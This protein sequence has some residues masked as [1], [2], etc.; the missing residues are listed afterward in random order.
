MERRGGEKKDEDQEGRELLG[1]C[2]HIP[3]GV[4]SNLRRILIE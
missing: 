1:I 3:V 2:V 4:D